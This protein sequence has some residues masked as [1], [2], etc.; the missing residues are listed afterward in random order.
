MHRS[1]RVGHRTLSL[2]AGY[3]A[4]YTLIIVRYAVNF[5]N[6]SKKLMPDWLLTTQADLHETG[7]TGVAGR[8][9]LV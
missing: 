6:F 2:L 4:T 1:V 3:H 9:G 5:R 8:E 7:P